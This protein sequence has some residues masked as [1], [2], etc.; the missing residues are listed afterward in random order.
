MNTTTILVFLALTLAP[1]KAIEGVWQQTDIR[2]IEST[3]QEKSGALCH[4]IW[5]ERRSYELN[6]IPSGVRGFYRNSLM[7][8]PLGLLSSD[9]LCKFEAP[10]TESLFFHNRNWDIAVE[11]VGLN[12]WKISADNGINIGPFDLE[13]SSF[14][15]MVEGK[16][17]KLIDHRSDAPI[18]FTRP[19]E[20]PQAREVLESSIDNIY[21][22]RCKAVHRKL[23]LAQEGESKIDQVCD[24]IQRSKSFTGRFQSMEV[25]RFESFDAI[26]LN[27]P[28]RPSTSWIDRRGVVYSYKLVFENQVLYGN[29]IVWEKEGQWRPA[30]IW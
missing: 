15:T 29:A 5:L 4:R 21:S 8:I 28:R 27:F 1:E 30:Y 13:V 17:G 26:P 12:K 7:A 24:L 18:E 22:G 25:E 19:S 11:A 3:R 14:S 23:E 20:W 9:P 2:S 16:D 6:A 10:A